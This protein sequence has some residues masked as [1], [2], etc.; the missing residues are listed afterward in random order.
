[1]TATATATQV[2][3]FV[4]VSAIFNSMDILYEVMTMISDLVF[5]QG[6]SILLLHLATERRAR[7]GRNK[8]YQIINTQFEKKETTNSYRRALLANMK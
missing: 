4:Y 6:P 3:L 7:K 8:V 1:V 2:K 5:L